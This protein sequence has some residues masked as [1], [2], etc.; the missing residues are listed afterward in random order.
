MLSDGWLLNTGTPV[1][2]SRLIDERFAATHNKL[3]FFAYTRMEMG[4]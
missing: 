2:P 1:I 4:I 3:I